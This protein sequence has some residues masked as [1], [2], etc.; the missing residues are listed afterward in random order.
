MKIKITKKMKSKLGKSL[1]KIQFYF[2]M[3]KIVI[4]KKTI[5]KL[6]K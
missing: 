3:T 5:L 1:K 4:N 2:K 6:R